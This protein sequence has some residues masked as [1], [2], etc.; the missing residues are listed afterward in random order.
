M[1]DSIDIIFL[2]DESGSMA[3]MCN[4]PIEAINNFVNEQKLVKD[5]STFSLYT[6]NTKVKTV[7]ED[8]PL[9]SVPAF[10]SDNFRPGSMTAL[11][12][13]MGKSMSDKKNSNK[14]KNVVMVILTDGQENSSKEYTSKQIKSMTTDLQDNFNWKFIYLGANQDAFA[15]GGQIGVGLCS[16]YSCTK[17]G[18]STATQNASRGVRNYKMSSL[19]NPDASLTV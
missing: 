18:L 16:N 4:E 6:F 15:T 13:A 7:W 19:S 2:L 10:T 5:N 12:D 9:Q 8:V 11:Y 1:C 14:N 3:S 17:G